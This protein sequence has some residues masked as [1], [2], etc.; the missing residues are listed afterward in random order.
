MPKN[1]LTRLEQQLIKDRGMSKP[2]AHNIAVKT[3]QDSGSIYRGTETL[4][5]KGEARTAMGAKGRAID[6]ASKRLNRPESDFIYSS[7]TNRAKVKP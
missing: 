4:T 2:T 7:R 1:I 3:L 5:A 6:R